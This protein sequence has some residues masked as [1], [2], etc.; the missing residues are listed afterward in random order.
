M[1]NQPL[2]V[3]APIQREWS[4]HHHDSRGSFR[5]K[6]QGT[7][8]FELRQRREKFVARGIMTESGIVAARAQRATIWDVDQKEYLDFASGI[9]VLNVGHGHPAVLEAV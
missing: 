8:G 9:G 2:I 3:Y 1:S 6:V 5:M 7:R 4:G